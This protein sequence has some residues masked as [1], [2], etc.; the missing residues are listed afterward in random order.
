MTK[1]QARRLYILGKKK[2]LN[3]KEQQE[4]DQFLKKV[5]K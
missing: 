4:L 1:H 3:D 2:V 5:I